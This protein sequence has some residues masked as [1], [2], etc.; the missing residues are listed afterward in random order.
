MD[1]DTRALCF[2][3][4]PRPCRFGVLPRRAPWGGGQ[5]H[6]CS[7]PGSPSTRSN[8]HTSH[9]LSTLP[10]TP[11]RPSVRLG[12]LPF[13]P[14]MSFTSSGKSFL[15]RRGNPPGCPQH[16]VLSSQR[17]PGFWLSLPNP[18]PGLRT[19]SRG[20]GQVHPTSLTVNGISRLASRTH[21]GG[22]CAEIS[23]RTLSASFSPPEQP[24]C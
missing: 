22:G 16:P 5:A 3:S 10:L 9:M 15:P 4:L 17:F 12:V 6:G 23:R 2:I 11:P 1:T 18:C 21:R 7:S 20:T 14:T 24:N 13:K 19:S 8:P